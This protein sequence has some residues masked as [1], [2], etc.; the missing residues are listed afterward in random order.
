MTEGKMQKPMTYKY[1]P[2]WARLSAALKYM[3]ETA[4]IRVFRAD[5]LL[6]HSIQPA[7]RSAISG[8][9][10]IYVA[11]VSGGETLYVGQ[12]TCIRARIYQHSKGSSPLRPYLENAAQRE[13]LTFSVWPVDHADVYETA[14]IVTF[15]PVLNR[16]LP[17]KFEEISGVLWREG[18]WI[19]KAREVIPI[20]DL[21]PGH[22]ENILRFLER[23][24]TSSVEDR[25]MNGMHMLPGE[26]LDAI[27]CEIVKHPAWPHL[28]RAA[29][30][31]C[32]W[33]ESPV[34]PYLCRVAA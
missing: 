30:K 26:S 28:M 29:N 8:Q 32:A 17:M 2:D 11:R 23:Q 18:Y 13:R 20:C 12:T 31:K 14:A 22:L 27:C 25:Q 1:V 3:R 34:Y 16:A 19:T 10:K 15:R 7:R 6:R 24:A 4:P 33:P 21:N 9:S 5:F